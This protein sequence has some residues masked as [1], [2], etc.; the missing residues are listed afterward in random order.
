MATSVTGHCAALVLVPALLNPNVLAARQLPPPAYQL[1]AAQAEV[2]PNLLY[3]V[4]L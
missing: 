4:A 2:P 3:A 1:A